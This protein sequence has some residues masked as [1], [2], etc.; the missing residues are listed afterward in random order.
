M[1][2]GDETQ[3]GR[4]NDLQLA[5]AVSDDNNPVL[6]DKPGPNEAQRVPFA[7]LRG[8]YVL[9]LRRHDLCD[10]GNHG[11]FQQNIATVLHSSDNQLRAIVPPA[12][13]RGVLP[14]P[15][16]TLLRAA[17]LQTA[18]PPQSLHADQRIFTR[19]GSFKRIAGVQCA[20]LLADHMLLLCFLHQV[21][22]SDVLLLIFGRG[23]AKVGFK[24]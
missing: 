15:P 14:A 10:G 11:P 4:L 19:S 21:R 16:P 6:N 7:S 12:A 3:R 17:G 24:I 2:T 8:R 1:L 5:L 22:L 9:L 20:A 13:A 18:V 23:E